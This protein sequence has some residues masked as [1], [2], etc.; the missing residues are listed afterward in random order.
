MMQMVAN[1]FTDKSSKNNVNNKNIGSTCYL[2]V[3]QSHTMPHPC[4][5]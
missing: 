4:L 2:L 1:S 5:R 3:R